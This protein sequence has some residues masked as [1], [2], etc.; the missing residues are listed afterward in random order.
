MPWYC[1]EWE[2]YALSIEMFPYGHV[3]TPLPVNFYSLPVY[4]SALF[5]GSERKKSE[6][7]VLEVG[8]CKTLTENQWCAWVYRI[9]GERAI[10]GSIFRH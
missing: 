9:L 8:S 10:Y 1:R 5:R 3:F 2:Q 7:P 6:R 4:G